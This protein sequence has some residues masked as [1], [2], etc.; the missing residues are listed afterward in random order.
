MSSSK[1]A[2]I[3]FAHQSQSAAAEKPHLVGPRSGPGA[4]PR[5]QP[6]PA[7]SP[8]PSKSGMSPSKELHVCANRLGIQLIGVLARTLRQRLIAVRVQLADADAPGLRE[9]DPLAREHVA[10][11]LAQHVETFLAHVIAHE[12]DVARADVRG[13]L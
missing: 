7:L 5:P 3:S 8:F 9:I 6:S 4:P 11:V 2:A 13:H 10:E 12:R 1:P